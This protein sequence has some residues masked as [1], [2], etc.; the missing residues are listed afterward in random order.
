MGVFYFYPMIDYLIVGSG[1]AGLCFAETAIQNGSSVLVFDDASQNSSQVAGGMY[2]PVVLKRLSPT[3]KAIEFMAYADT[4]YADLE[5][6]FNNT[7]DFKYPVCRIFHSVEEQNN[8]FQAA[9]HPVLQKFLDTNLVKEIPK[10]IDAP[11]GMGKVK[12]T[13]YVDTKQ[14]LNSYR[15]MLNQQGLL[16]QESFN[17]NAIR[18][19]E[20]GIEYKHQ[21][22]KQVIFAEGFGLHANPFFNQLPLEGTKGEV[23]IVRIPNFSTQYIV[24]AGVFIIPLGG[25]LFKVGA[26]YHWTDKTSIPTSE[27]KEQLIA[28]LK[29]FLKLDFKVVDHLAGVRPTVSDRR[30]MIGKH[31]N[32]KNLYVL[33]GLGTRGVILGP[34]MAKYLYEHIEQ[35]SPIDPLVDIKRFRKI[36]W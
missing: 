29:E 28:Q 26:T 32:H 19:L 21:R 3:W 10:G 9:D 25:D 22:F 11:F 12:H 36:V 7:F 8:W 35:N 15:T 5:H 18:F 20:D 13:G 31:P 34:N 6:R 27:G 2:N 14:L 23:L 24:K 1:L 33:N 4:F 17:Y 16:L 30:P